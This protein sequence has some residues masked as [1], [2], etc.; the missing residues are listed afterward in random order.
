M[1]N[2]VVLCLACGAASG[3]EPIV[4]PSL[5]V[6]FTVEGQRITVTT[7][8]LLSKIPDSA[9]GF[10]VNLQVDL[11]DFQR[12]LLPI[13]RPQL[14]KNDDCGERIALQDA[15]IAPRAPAGNM[16]VKL[17]YERWACVKA[18]GKKIQKRLVAGNGVVQ[19]KLTP[20]LEASA[21]AVRLSAE[22]DSID[23]DGSLGE[24]LH[25][26]S[27]GQTLHEKITQSVQS[28]IDRG[29]NWNATIPP[30]LQSVL[31]LRTVAFQDAGSGRL[32]L[33]VDGE[34]RLPAER[35][36]MLLLQLKQRQ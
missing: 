29:T 16:T 2:W 8:G 34:V 12:N 19:I 30:A 23:A 6:P 14:E 5:A 9:D 33:A 35:M 4:I 20:Q 28:S 7:G 32:L 15:V 24:L 31:A 1:K 13:L 3:A 22:V 36:Q 18:L 25:S 27:L 17:H 10:R 11:S 21:T 26:G